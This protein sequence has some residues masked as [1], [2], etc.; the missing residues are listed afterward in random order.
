[1]ELVR[2]EAHAR[3]RPWGDGAALRLECDADAITV[4]QITRAP[5][6]VT[7]EPRGS[8]RL[9]ASGVPRGAEGLIASGGLYV[10]WCPTH[11]CCGQ[12]AAGGLAEV[13]T[14]HCSD[15]G[16]CETVS[17]TLGDCLAVYCAAY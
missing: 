7:G 3:R 13:V 6:P 4:E 17:D 16:D 15:D 1:M 8:T 9:A 5:D 14:V 10:A 12:S 11:G 2:R